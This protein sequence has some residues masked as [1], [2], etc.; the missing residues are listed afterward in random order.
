VEGAKV[1]DF[2][3]RRLSGGS[4]AQRRDALGRRRGRRVDR[5][6]LSVRQT[7]R[8]TLQSGAAQALQALGPLQVALGGLAP[9]TARL[10]APNS[11]VCRF[12]YPY[13]SDHSVYREYCIEKK[14][15]TDW[16]SRRRVIEDNVIEVALIRY[17]NLMDTMQR[18]LVLKNK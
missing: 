5:S 16:A 12:R 6:A 2:G 9:G 3:R 17:E 13:R 8:G 10:L 15:V 14:A 18:L 4:F 7:R 11:S 1:A